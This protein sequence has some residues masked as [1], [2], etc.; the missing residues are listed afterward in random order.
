[1]LRFLPRALSSPLCLA[2]Q[3]WVTHTEIKRNTT[4]DNWTWFSY[5]MWKN[6]TH[7]DFMDAL[8]RNPKAFTC[9]GFHMPRHPSSQPHPPAFPVGPAKMHQGQMGYLILP[10]CSGSLPGLPPRWTWLGNLER[11]ASLSHRLTPFDAKEKARPGRL[12]PG[13][14]GWW[15]S[16]VRLG[17]RKQHGTTTVLTRHL[18]LLYQSVDRN[19]QDPWCSGYSSYF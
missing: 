3:I 10:A 2:N 17:P 12:H 11:E 16:P 14:D 1:M 4:E 13:L 5:E 18:H 19:R 15:L 9:S 8:S 6:K 7:R